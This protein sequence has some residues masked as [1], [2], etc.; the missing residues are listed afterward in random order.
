MTHFTSNP[1]V[2]HELTVDKQRAFVQ[3]TTDNSI[4]DAEANKLLGAE[5][6]DEQGALDAIPE[7]LIEGAAAGIIIIRDTGLL[8]ATVMFAPPSV[9]SRI[10]RHS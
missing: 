9:N 2:W 1:D 5:A 4:L 10:P 7:P 6:D 8:L 3:L